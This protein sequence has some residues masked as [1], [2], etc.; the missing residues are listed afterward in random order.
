MKNHGCKWVETTRDGIHGNSRLRG[1]HLVCLSY[2]GVFS[3]KGWLEN[4]P[5][6]ISVQLKMPNQIN[7]LEENKDRWSLLSK[8]SSM[9]SH[10][11]SPT[12]KIRL[13]SWWQFLPSM[14][15]PPR[16]PSTTPTLH[17]FPPPPRNEIR[18]RQVD[19]DQNPCD[20]G[21]RG[22]LFSCLLKSLYGG[23]VKWWYPQ[24]TPKWSF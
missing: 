9:I 17:E 21:L 24:N 20:L 6:I 12:A 23:F 5:V 2:H 7:H 16:Y 11:Q 14:K 18:K 19:L 1:P 13:G 15:G 22:I 10:H 4:P 8:Q 3:A